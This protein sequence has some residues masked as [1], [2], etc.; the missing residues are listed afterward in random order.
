MKKTVVLGAS[1]NPARYSFKA[2]KSL[3]RHGHD[4]VPVGFRPGVISVSVKPSGMVEKFIKRGQPEV[5]DVHTVSL[6]IGPQRQDEFKDYIISLKPKRV[7]FNPGTLNEEFMNQ[8]ESLG[9][10]T[11]EGC[12]L[13][14]L[15]SDQY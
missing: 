12:Q 10:E 9:I 11:I 3:V 13:V 4:V 15:S 1:P 8:L 14:M 5:E 7:I 6:Y 2:V